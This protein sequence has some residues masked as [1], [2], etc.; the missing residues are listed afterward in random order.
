M[1]TSWRCSPMVDYKINV[2]ECLRRSNFLL[3]FFLYILGIKIN[4]QETV[5]RIFKK[6]S[7]KV[8]LL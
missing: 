3:S 6:E 1:I 8:A 2:R 5:P 7:Q 4:I